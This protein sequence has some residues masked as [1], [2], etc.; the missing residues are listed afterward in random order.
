MKVVNDSITNPIS[1]EA[2]EF[3]ILASSHLTNYEPIFFARIVYHDF[4]NK[5][6]QETIVY[7]DQETP[8]DR[9][10]IDYLRSE[11]WL[12]DY[13][14]VFS[15]TQP[16]LEHLSAFSYICPLGY[17]NQEP[18]YIHVIAKEPLSEN[19]QQQVKQS[20]MLLSKYLNLY[21]DRN[22]RVSEIKI[23]EQI[24]QRIGHQL[25]NSLSLI[26]LYV[27]NLCFG[28]KDHDL[29]PQAQII[30]QNIQNLDLKLNELIECSQ[31]ECLKLTHQDLRILI[32]ESIDSLQPSIQQKHLNIRISDTSVLLNVDRLQMKQVFDNLLSNAVHFS[33]I[34]GT[35]VCN[36]Q[37]FQG[38]VL[39]KIAD[40]GP[41][42][43][44]EDL[45]KIFNP[46]YS[47]RE[48]GT[49][50]GLTIAKKIVLDHQG[51]LWAQNLGS[52]GAQFSLILSR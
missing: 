27:Q 52:G 31:G 2:K 7:A 32:L 16:N 4:L 50:L 42:I 37:I 38:E 35:I 9:R 44:P 12:L 47:R 30:S 41:G 6:R 5:T 25:R 29:Q 11:K 48:G 33:P 18:E 24:L 20:A 49:G 28:L 51:S 46:F 3:C 34:F 22:S 40:E 23:L 21:I 39:I 19:L 1:V 17:R 43:S 8:L 10:S 36:W 26:S 15:I 45:P 14:P 13:P